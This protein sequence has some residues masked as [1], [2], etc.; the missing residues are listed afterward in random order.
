MPSSPERRRQARINRRTKPPRPP[1]AFFLFRNEVRMQEASLNQQQ[2]SKI[3]AE[4]WRLLPDCEKKRYA[5]L[6][7]AE[8]IRQ[9]VTSSYHHNT[10]NI[11]EDNPN[12]VFEIVYPYG[13][14]TEIFINQNNQTSASFS[15]TT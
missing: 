4:R 3:A 1:N 14:E 2:V 6:A 12:A 7:E 5:R 10:F 13:V 15:Q 11:Q 8:A 9:N